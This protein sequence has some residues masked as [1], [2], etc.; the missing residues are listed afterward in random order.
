MATTVL[1]IDDDP[2][3][4]EI[5]EALLYYNGFDV[6]IAADGVSGIESALHR[7]PDVIL[8]DVMMPGI[9]GLTAA[10]SIHTNPVTS[11]IPIICMSAYGV[12]LQRVREAGALDFVPKP[13]TGDTLVR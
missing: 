9:N 10:N 13:A 1:L 6:L 12:S 3:D 2:N 7:K 4:R 5:Y 8:I 11:H